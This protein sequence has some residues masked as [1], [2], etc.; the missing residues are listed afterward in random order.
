MAIISSTNLLCLLPYLHRNMQKK[1][2]GWII[3]ELWSQKSHII[4]GWKSLSPPHWRR[5]PH[6][7]ETPVYAPVNAGFNFSRCLSVC[8]TLFHRQRNS[9]RVMSE[10]EFYS[11]WKDIGVVHS[12]PL[13]RGRLLKGTEWCCKKTKILPNDFQFNTTTPVFSFRKISLSIAEASGPI[14]SYFSVNERISQIFDLINQSLFT[15]FDM[16]TRIPHVPKSL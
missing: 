15:D 11:T 4:T 7:N 3:G 10:A 1:K 14:S 12:L 16:L 9:G 13:Q 5:H 2:L 8:K 6:R